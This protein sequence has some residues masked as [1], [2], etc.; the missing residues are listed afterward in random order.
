MA[1]IA[2]IEHSGIGNL[3]LWV[4]ALKAMKK[5]NHEIHLCIWERTQDVARAFDFIDQIHTKHPL[6]ALMED[7][8]IVDHLLFSPVGSLKDARM[9]QFVKRGPKPVIFLQPPKPWD[10]SEAHLKSQYAREMGFTDGMPNH[11]IKLPKENKE[12]LTLHLNNFICMNIGYLKTDHWHLK[13][14]GNKN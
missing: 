3:L 10:I 8:G 5:M 4:P 9:A 12:N 13:H 1:K 11:L 7:I 2:V 6:L 14:W